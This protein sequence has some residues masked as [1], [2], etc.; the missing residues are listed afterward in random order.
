MSTFN[1]GLGKVEVGLRWDPS[2]LG[3]PDHDLDL[4]AAVYTADAPYT[5]PDYVVHFDSRSPDGTVMLNRDSRTGQGFGDDEVMTLEFDR[6]AERYTR[7]VVGAAIQ[8][9]EGHL[10]FGDIANTGVRI[11]EGYTELST[12]DLA[13]VAD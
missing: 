13:E 7:V 6:I 5:E 10:V 2:P 4:V 9:T 12:S 11:A 3:S 8:Q 1:K